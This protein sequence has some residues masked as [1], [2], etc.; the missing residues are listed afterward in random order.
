MTEIPKDLVLTESQFREVIERA[1]RA[2]AREPGITV[3]ALRQVAAEAE[4]DQEKLEAALR[5]VLDSAPPASTPAMSLSGRP[6]IGAMMGEILPRQ[7]RVIVF[8]LIAAWLGWFSAHIGN[9]LNSGAMGFVDVPVSIVMLVMTLANS[10]NRRVDGRVGRFIAESAATCAG[11]TI[12]WSI[13]HGR[14]TD[15]LVTWLASGIGAAAVWGWLFV[16]RRG[17]SE[18]AVT[19]TSSPAVDAPASSDRDERSVWPSITVQ[20]AA[21]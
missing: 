2:E 8:A 14:V 3:E 6:S 5:E 20:P 17:P 4:I 15:D 16:R 12:A 19:A 10:M 18:P 11:F 7:G 9:T 1:A 21:G 13:T